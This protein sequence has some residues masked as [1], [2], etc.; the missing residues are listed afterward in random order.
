MCVCV[1]VCRR[2]SRHTCAHTQTD[3]PDE[4]YDGGWRSCFPLQMLPLFL[5]IQPLPHS[6]SLPAA[7]FMRQAPNV[8]LTVYAI[9]TVSVSDYV[10]LGCAQPFSK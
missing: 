6:L 9:H 1:C 4:D 10:K 7:L 2:L 8:S 3:T 5:A